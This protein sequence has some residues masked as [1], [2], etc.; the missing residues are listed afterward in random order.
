[1][2]AARVDPGREPRLLRALI[3]KVASWYIPLLDGIYHAAIG[4]YH[5]VYTM[6]YTMVYIIQ[7]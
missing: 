5:M 7:K 2:A 1:M 4:I 3:W 6:V